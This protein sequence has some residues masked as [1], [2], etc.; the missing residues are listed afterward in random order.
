MQLKFWQMIWSLYL[1][2]FK[3]TY[4]LH[5]AQRTL[6]DQHSDIYMLII[7]GKKDNLPSVNREGEPEVMFMSLHIYAIEEGIDAT[8]LL[9]MLIL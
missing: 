5:T 2:Q 1:F 6:R 4:Y 9:K 7:T 3:Y 8:F